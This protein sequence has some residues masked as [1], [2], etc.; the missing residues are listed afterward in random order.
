VLVADTE[1]RWT[2]DKGSVLPVAYT[3][4]I[5]QDGKSLGTIECRTPR[6][7]ASVCYHSIT[8]LGERSGECEY[9]LDCALPSLGE[10]EV[11]LRV[12]GRIADAQVVKQVDEMSLRVLEE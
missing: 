8:S 10:G 3:V 7:V 9:K 1:G 6:R 11:V 12:E 4:G 5:T 2:G